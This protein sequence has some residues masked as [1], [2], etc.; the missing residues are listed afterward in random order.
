[1]N[2][3]IR[4]NVGG[5]S[6]MTIRATLTS[7]TESLLAKMFSLDSDLPPARVTEDGSYFIDACPHGFSVI[8]N[9]L[10]YRKLIL[11]NDTK[12]ENVI[13]VAEYFAIN[14][15]RD[16]LEDHLAS[17]KPP[18]LVKPNVRGTTFETD[19][20]TL[21]DHT[22]SKLCFFKNGE[23]YNIDADPRAFNVILNW[24]RYKEII[25]GD[26]SRE[27]DV[28]PVAESLGLNFKKFNSA[29]RKA[30]AELQ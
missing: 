12:P 3:I 2:D 23:I 7:S 19:E 15:L 22:N 1:M 24:L 4:L 13:Q 9:W 11:D 5:T 14:D 30:V 29:L 6:F 8:L 10:R 27:E 18:G 20:S 25:L 16:A 26:I 17:S 28:I 21:N